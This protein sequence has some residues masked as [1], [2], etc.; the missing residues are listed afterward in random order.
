MKWTAGVTS[1]LIALGLFG[2][3]GMDRSPDAQQSAVDNLAE[4]RNELVRARAQL[5]RTVHSLNNLMTAPPGEIRGA[6]RQ[7]ASN[8]ETLR[9]MAEQLAQDERATR[10]RR[11]DYL[12]AWERTQLNVQSPRL[13]NVAAHR[14]REVSQSLGQVESSLRRANENVDPLISQLEDIAY[15][16]GNDPTPA[17][18]AAVKQ[19]GIAGSAQRRAGAVENDLQTA[20]VGLDRALAVL[21]PQPGGAAVAAT[22]E[23]PS[24]SR[25]DRDASG[26][27]EQ[28]EADQIEGL[29]FMSADTDRDRQLSRSEYEAATQPSQ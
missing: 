20:Q 10:E 2:C 1:L 17:G 3:A 11:I 14:Q 26:A 22:G 23:M 9:N 8:V 4:N 5:D 16:T 7:Y 27:I 29:D 24:F 21:A 12:T 25:A 13:R 28:D 19:S 6:Q 18:I 15:V